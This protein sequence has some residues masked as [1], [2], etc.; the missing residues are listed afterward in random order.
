MLGEVAR[1]AIGGGDVDAGALAGDVA[2]TPC[3]GC[4]QA[5]F[6]AASLWGCDDEVISANGDGTAMETR[7]ISELLPA[8][9]G[10][11]NLEDVDCFRTG[12]VRR[13]P[14]PQRL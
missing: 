12:G 4:R 3:G 10:P 2:C 11:A 7:W 1:I 8:G 13:R 14:S 6:G 5:I 9:F